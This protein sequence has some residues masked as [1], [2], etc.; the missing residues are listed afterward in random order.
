MREQTRV[1]MLPPGHKRIGTGTL[2]LATCGVL[3]GMAVSGAA[4]WQIR[5]ET[6]QAEYHA[7]A[8]ATVIVPATLPGAVTVHVGEG[9]Y[10]V[11]QQIAPGTYEVAARG[12]IRDCTWSRRRDLGT[13]GKSILAG[14][15]I[16]RNDKDQFITV[17]T[18]DR[19]LV[20]IG[21][22]TWTRLAAEPGQPNATESTR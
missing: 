14:S 21:E 20:L 16:K 8:P 18:T 5:G 12:Q 19:W 10:R 1:D 17:A 3:A 9:T 4:G 11:P 6:P 2:I 15:Q 22:C 13:A 7:G